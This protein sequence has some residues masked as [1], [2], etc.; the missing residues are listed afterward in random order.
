MRER[1]IFFGLILFSFISPV[2]SAEKPAFRI[3]GTFTEWSIYA[4]KYHV[5]D[6]PAE[7]LT[8][9]IYAHAIIRNGE[10]AFHDRE[11]AVLKRFPSSKEI[12]KNL[13]GNFGRLLS[14]KKKHPHLKTI[15]SVGGWSKSS[16]FSTVARTPKA[17]KQFAI[18]CIEFLRHYDFDGLDVDWEHPVSGGSRRNRSRPQDKANYVLLLKELRSRLDQQSKKDKKKYL[19]TIAAPANVKILKNYDLKGITPLVD[20]INVMAY[21]YHGSWSRVTNFNAPLYSSSKDP[22]KDKVEK[23]QFNVH[24]TVRAYLAAKVPAHKINLGVPFYGRGWLDVPNANQGL[25]QKPGPTPPRGSWQPG[26]YDYKDLAKNYVPKMKRS[27]HKEAKV[28]WLYDSTTG[29]MISYD[30][31]ESMKLK[32]QYAKK[33]KLG[34][35]MIWELSADDKKSSLL[36]AIRDVLTPQK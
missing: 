26:V 1:R 23:A 25:Y 3:V 7:K 35:M 10:I 9:L 34:G 16:E 21:D 2:W 28:P 27:F 17:R 18:S 29:L 14:L 11:A 19:L 15:I 32:A 22:S 30:D 33:N 36:G 12:K 6:V 31:P 24:A 5:T 20:W 8:H 4:R 13:Y